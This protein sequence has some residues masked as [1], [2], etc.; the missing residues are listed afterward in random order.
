MS[1]AQMMAL[2]RDLTFPLLRLVPEGRILSV[3]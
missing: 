1:S 2:A 3:L